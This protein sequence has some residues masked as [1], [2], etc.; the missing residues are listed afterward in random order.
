MADN[1]NPTI[2]PNAPI[3]A[4]GAAPLPGGGVTAPAPQPAQV[5]V[6][7]PDKNKK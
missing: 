1:N 3:I 6:S 4:P 7:T 5:E 2:A